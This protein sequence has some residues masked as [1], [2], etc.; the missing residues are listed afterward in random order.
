MQ[1]Y[2]LLS[3]EEKNIISD[4]VLNAIQNDVREVY[5]EN[6]LHHKNAYSMLVWD[7]IGSNVIDDLKTTR[8]KV[9]RA[10]RG[11]FSFDLIA[12]EENQ[13]VYTIMKKSNI[14]KIR[15][16]RKFSHYLWSLTSINFDIKVEEGQLNLFSIESNNEYREE[17]KKELLS[18]IEAI[19][20]RHCMIVINDDN[21]QFPYIQLCVYDMNLNCVF[22]ETWKEPVIW[23]YSLENDENIED[24]S[25]EKPTIKF[26]DD[27]EENIIR[28]KEEKKKEEEEKKEG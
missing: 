8:L 18:G 5:S 16:E 9:V 15:K 7:F 26:K 24:I 21:K 17:T 27:I 19:I 12:D 2:C 25:V 1:K 3:T 11:R 13:T 10:K 22:E 4:A 6:N 20:N 28:F 14:E 23:N